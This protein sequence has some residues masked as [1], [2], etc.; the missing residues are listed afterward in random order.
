MNRWVIY[1]GLAAALALWSH[2]H[3]GSEATLRP[4]GGFEYPGYRITELEPFTI[5]ARVLGRR[6][7]T[8]DRESA[9]APTD[10]VLGW[11]PMADESVL[12]KL[13]ISQANRWYFWRATTLPIAARE[14]AEHSA[15]MHLIAASPGTA[16][17]LA[18]V[19][20]DDRVRISGQLVEVR[21]DDGWRWRSSLS[22]SDTGA[23]SCEVVWLERLEVL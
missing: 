21:G 2:F 14:I 18:R 3:G 7:Y 19:R 1:G 23:S 8:N 20:A 6:D 15:N 5:E 4:E 17:A 10:L 22:R 9:L 11:G 16:H 12:E 13:D